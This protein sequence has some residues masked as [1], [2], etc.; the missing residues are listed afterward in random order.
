MLYVFESQSNMENSDMDMDAVRP[1]EVEVH[2]T[3]NNFCSICL[4][5][6]I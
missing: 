4:I 6:S 1:V 3:Q 5:Y 2:Q